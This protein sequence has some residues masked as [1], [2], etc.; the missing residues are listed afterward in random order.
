MQNTQKGFTLIELLVSTIVGAA[1]SAT[2][3]GLY[4]N[5]Q[6]DYLTQKGISTT[7]GKANDGL[8]YIGEKIARSNEDKSFVQLVS[9][10]QGSGIVLNAAAFGAGV[11]VLNANMSQSE[12]GHSYATERSDQLVIQYLPKFIKGYDCEGVNIASV[13]T[14]VVEKYFVKVNPQDSTQLSLVCDA[15][16][17]KNGVFTGLDGQT[18]TL[19]NSVDYFRVLLGVSQ[20]VPNPSGGGQYQHRNMTIAQYNAAATKYPITSVSYGVLLHSENSIGRND[21]INNQATFRLLDKDVKLNTS[22]AASIKNNNIY[23]TFARTVA[24]NDGIGGGE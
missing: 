5:S 7:V 23:K 16:R 15:G 13:S 21:V 14:Y 22:A 18:T 3:I 24:V 8:S 2:A 11:S 19:I 12:T 1:L 9:N 10:V 6:R 17:F 4:M 20:Y